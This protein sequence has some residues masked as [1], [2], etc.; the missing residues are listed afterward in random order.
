MVFTLPLLDID[1]NYNYDNIAMPRMARI[2]R[3]MPSQIEVRSF[4]AET[5]CSL[6]SSS[7]PLVVIQNNHG[8]DTPFRYNFDQRYPSNCNF[9]CTLVFL[10]SSS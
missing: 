3:E 10:L 7:S 4:Y 5:L 6:S 1:N 9:Y 2:I 8:E